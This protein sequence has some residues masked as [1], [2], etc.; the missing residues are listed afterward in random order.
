M[1]GN[2]IHVA[3]RNAAQVVGHGQGRARDLKQQERT[4]I[5]AVARRFSAT[6]EKR[7]DPTDAYIMCFQ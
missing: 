1:G 6:W 3:A 7:S 2:K 5:E 4:A